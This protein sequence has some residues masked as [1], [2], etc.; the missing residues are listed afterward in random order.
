MIIEDRAMNG[1]GDSGGWGGKKDERKVKEVNNAKV[2]MT[3]SR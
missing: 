1:N 3:T 2:T